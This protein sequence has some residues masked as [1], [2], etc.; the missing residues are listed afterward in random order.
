MGGLEL[1]YFLSFFLMEF[2][3][4]K[5]LFRLGFDMDFIRIGIGILIVGGVLGL[6]EFLIGDIICRIFWKFFSVVRDILL[7]LL[8]VV[9][10][11]WLR[12]IFYV[13][14]KFFVLGRRKKNL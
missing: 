1:L 12:R 6:F 4:T 3:F 14:E 7:F 13:F 10:C 8:S 5:G 9:D 11:M 2:V